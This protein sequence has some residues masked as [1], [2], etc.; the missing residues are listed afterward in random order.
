MNDPVTMRRQ[1]R[2]ELKRLRAERDLTQRHVAEQLDWSPS[3]IIRIEKGVVAIGVTDL[4]AL[5]R[6]YDVQDK[7]T[8][9]A[10]VAMA[11]GSKR[12]PFNEYRDKLA[13]ETLRYF[14]YESS[15]AILRQF[16]PL[17]IPGLL[18]TEEYARTLLKDLGYSSE[19]IETIWAVRS[20]RQEILDRDSP[21]E[22]FFVLDEATIRRVVGSE[23]LMRRQLNRLVE[24]NT[25]PRVTIR[26]MPF[27]A[28]A[29]IGMLGP[30]TYL[31]FPD[32]EDPN[33]L[34]VEGP[35]G[36]A[37]LRDEED[38]TARYLDSFFALEKS[39]LPAE[40]LEKVLLPPS[41]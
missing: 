34:Y 4:Q 9:D 5:L 40:D 39:A 41:D 6:L 31:E 1:L 33:V 27:S 3:K 21:P 10:L 12:L 22:M 18:Q 17:V 2:A 11:R 32:D 24:L 20:E 29:Y 14:G 25:N 13:P 15:A 7:A 28:G 35:L 30:F 36:D 37:V 19:R 8:I 38:L 26:V 23:N 16:E